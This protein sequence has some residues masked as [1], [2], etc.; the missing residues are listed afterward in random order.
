MESVSPFQYLS[1][2]YDDLRTIFKELKLS[3]GNIFIIVDQNHVLAEFYQLL[4]ANFFWFILISVSFEVKYVSLKL[5]L[6]FFM[7]DNSFGTS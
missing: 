5:R 4:L 6:S 3:M 2:S 7:V 1:T